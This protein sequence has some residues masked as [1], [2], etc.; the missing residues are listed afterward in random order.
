MV[1]TTTSVGAPVFGLRRE[2]DRL[3]DDAFGRDTGRGPWLPAVD[4]RDE[5]QAIVIETELPGVDPAQVEVTAE[6]GVLS[7][8]GEK[9]RERKEG[10]EG[11][12]HLLERTWGR[13]ERTFQLPQ[14]L[15]EAQIQASFAHG[16]LTVRLPKAALPQPRRIEITTGT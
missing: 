6:K 1:F 13:F 15:D 9:Q 2:I 11:R 5:D 3:F 10:Q 14:G 7:I 12:F 4:I 8:R 16:V